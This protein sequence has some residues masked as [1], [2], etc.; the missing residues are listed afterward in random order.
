[1]GFFFSALATMMSRSSKR[2]PQLGRRGAALG[3]MTSER[4]LCLCP[5]DYRIGYPPGLLVDNGTHEWDGRP[6]GR[7]GRM[8]A[9]EQHVEKAPS[10]YTS[11]AVVTARPAL[12]RAAYSGVNA[13]PASRVSALVPAGESPRR[14]A[15]RAAWRCR[16]RAI[17]PDHPR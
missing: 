10:A 5:A 8:L 11:V 12:P 1:M 17:S 13:A 2:S 14:V 3:G 15:P 6:N 4:F 9:A 7:A 16:S